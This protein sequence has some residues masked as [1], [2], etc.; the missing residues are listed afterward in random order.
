MWYYTMFN[1]GTPQTYSVKPCQVF[2]SVTFV[3]HHDGNVAEAPKDCKLTFYLPTQ[4]DEKSFLKLIKYS[5]SDYN[6]YY[7]PLKDIL[8]KIGEIKQ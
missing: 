5:T 7:L 8:I 1:A 6:T 2:L 4:K 3:R